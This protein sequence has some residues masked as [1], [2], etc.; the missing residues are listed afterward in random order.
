MAALRNLCTMG[1]YLDRGEV[2]RTGTAEE[3]ITLYETRNAGAAA[4]TWQR[5]EE[6]TGAL[7][8][9]SIGVGVTGSQPA[10]SLQVDLS[11]RSAGAHKPAIVAIDIAAAGTVLM[12]AIPRLDGFLQSAAAEH[13]LRVTV[14]LPPLIPGRYAVN[15]WAGS[16]LTET[17]DEVKE[18]V[19]FEVYDSPTAARTL[20]HTRDH[21]YV[22]PASSV[23]KRDDVERGR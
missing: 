4:S 9:T 14:D 11:L 10:L 19:S 13:D 23:R 12:Q 1:L 5:E 3:C 22:V 21:G 7:T 8:I 20:P 18:E 6:S 15:V 2:V 16:S 17:L